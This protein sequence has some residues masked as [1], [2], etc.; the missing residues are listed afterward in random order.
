MPLPELNKVKGFAGQARSHR[1]FRVSL[2]RAPVDADTTFGVTPNAPRFRHPGNREA[3]TPGYAGVARCGCAFRSGWN[4]VDTQ[5]RDFMKVCIA[6]HEC[7]FRLGYEQGRGLNGVGC[8]QAMPG[9]EFG[10][11]IQYWRIHRDD[12]QP[13][14]VQELVNLLQGVG[15]R[16]AHG[17]HAAFQPTQG[18]NRQRRRVSLALETLE[19]APDS[20]P[21]SYCQ[22]WC[23]GGIEKG[24]VSGWNGSTSNQPAKG[25]TPP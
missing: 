4:A 8:T 21:G 1:V 5:A 25:D 7:T 18:G 24:G 15:V 14:I 12:H 22:K 17:A 9:T 2:T 11:Q 10:C 16:G 19:R 13:G 23:T 3:V 6:G 20:L